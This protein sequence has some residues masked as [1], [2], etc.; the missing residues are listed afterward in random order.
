MKFKATLFAE[1][2]CTFDLVSTLTR[3]T[4]GCFFRGGG[5]R[6][7]T[8]LMKFSSITWA[9]HP[10]CVLLLNTWKTSV[11]LW[12]KSLQPLKFNANYGPS[13][14]R[15][16]NWPFLFLFITQPYCVKSEIRHMLFCWGVTVVRFTCLQSRNYFADQHSLTDV[17][18][19][20]RQ[21]VRLWHAF[22]DSKQLCLQEK[23]KVTELILRNKK[24]DKSSTI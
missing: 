2:Y 16:T 10:P 13:G 12:L 23:N 14:V 7:T 11:L 9:A 21:C 1:A 8:C 15:M 20:Q 24:T 18:P 5:I 22:L 17:T 3:W 19:P 6:Y 4:L